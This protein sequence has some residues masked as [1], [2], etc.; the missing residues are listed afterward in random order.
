MNTK[1]K[2]RDNEDDENEEAD[3]EEELF[4][5]NGT[6]VHDDENNFFG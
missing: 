1:V 5:E 2:N 6:S 3:P 4:Y